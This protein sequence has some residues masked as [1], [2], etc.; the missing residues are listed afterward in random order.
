MI[1]LV[2][3]KQNI[4]TYIILSCYPFHKKG[5]ICPKLS[6]PHLRQNPCP[7]QGTPVQYIAKERNT[8]Y[9]F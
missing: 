5:K 8:G 3:T 7:F 4:N 9:A 2:K 1:I 6:T